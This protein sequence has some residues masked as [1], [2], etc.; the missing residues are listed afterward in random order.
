MW[1]LDFEASGLSNLSYPVEVGFTN[2]EEAYSFLIKPMDHWKYWDMKAQDIHGIE[3]E[4]LNEKGTDALEIVEFLNSTLKGSVVYCDVIKWDGFWLNVLFSDNG[5]SP[6]FELIDIQGIFENTADLN[7]YM[8]KNE[9]LN[10]SGSYKKHRALDDAEVIYNSLEYL[11][12]QREKINA[13]S[14]SSLE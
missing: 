9:E 5:V 12:Y 1:V 10:N 8:V 7:N 14:R 11:L 3:R 13:Q 4:Y 6:A 2:G